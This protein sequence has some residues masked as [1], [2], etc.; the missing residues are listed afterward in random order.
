MKS[1]GTITNG[2]YNRVSAVIAY[3]NNQV[4]FSTKPRWIRLFFGV[5]GEALAPAKEQFRINVSDVIS[6]KISET[7]TGKPVFEIIARKNFC[8][9]TFNCEDELTDALKNDLKDKVVD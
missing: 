1:R 7:W 6:L 4:I 5:I 8:E 9:V 2:E 3:E